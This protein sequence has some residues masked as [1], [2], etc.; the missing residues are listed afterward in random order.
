MTKTTTKTK[1]KLKY[2]VG[3][4]V[5]VKATINEVY[6]GLDVD[7]A[8]YCI[9]LTKDT[10]TY[11]DLYDIKEDCIEGLAPVLEPTKPGTVVVVANVPWLLG[12]DGLWW[13]TLDNEGYGEPRT[14]G[15]VLSEGTPKVVWEP[16]D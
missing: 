11:P 2:S 1:K 14:W 8:D 13:S 7:Y 12:H 4:V 6:K 3:D 10:M 15:Q 16:D 9:Q 5:L